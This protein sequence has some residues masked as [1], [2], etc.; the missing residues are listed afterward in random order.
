MKTSPV[1]ALLSAT[2]LCALISCSG[3]RPSS[4]LGDP[5]S[6]TNHPWFPLASGN[7]AFGKTVAVD[8][9]ITCDSCHPPAAPSFKDVSCTGCHLHALPMTN[10][11]HLGEATYDAGTSA[12]VACHPLGEKVP[13][14]HVGISPDERGGCAECHAEGAAFA[15]LP[16]ADGQPH[17]AVSGD[18]GGCH[19]RFDAWTG[20]SGAENGRFDPARDWVLTA[21]VPTFSAT[22]IVRLEPLPQSLHMPMNHDALDAGLIAQCALCHPGAAA[23]GG[24][25]YPGELHST[26]S[27]LGLPQPRACLDCH[28]ATEPVGFV[29]PLRSERSPQSGAMRHEAVAWD[30]GVAS[31][32]R[33][34]PEECAVCH[35]TPSRVS[36][37]WS[38]ALVDGGPPAFHAPLAAASLAQPTS[39]LD[40]HA[41]SR[42][43]TL[44]SSANAALPPGLVFDHGADDA[45]GD[46]GGCHASTTTWTG[47]DF[48]RAGTPAPATCLPCH[49][50]E[51]P[52]STAGWQSTTYARSPFDYGLN[53][54]GIGH[55]GDEDCAACHATTTRWSDGHFPHG[56]G[57]LAATTCAACHLSQ[58]P[59]GVVQSF[60]H[61]LNGMGDCRACHQATVVAGRYVDYVNPATGALP[62]G[63]WKGGREY[64]GD[65][66]VTSPTQ[67][68]RITQ[69]TLQRADG[70]FVTGMTSATS[71]FYNAMLH[72]S[73]ALPP[74]LDAGSA[75]TPN[76]ASCWHCHAHVNGVVTSYLEGKY[77]EALDGFRATP[78]AGVTPQ[79][80][81]ASRCL[82]CHEPM[83]PRTIVMKAASPL[84]PMD[85]SVRFTAPVTLGGQAVTNL[86]QVD[87]SVCHADPGGAWSDGVFHARIGAANPVD[88]VSCHYPLMVAPSAD[89][90]AGTTYVMRHRSSQLTLQ[91]CEA[92]HAMALGR[93]AMTPLSA[94]QWR[95]GLL[96]PNVT[97]QPTR[98]LD[99]H[100]PSEPAAS[101]QGTVVW[102][103]TGGGGTATNGGQWMSHAVPAVT[104]RDCAV[105]HQADAK[106][107]GSAWSKSTQLHANASPPGTCAS[108]HGTANGRG[109]VI[110][111]NN[112]LPLGLTNSKTTTTASTAP[113]VKDQLSHADVNVTGRDCGF[114]HSLTTP[115]DWKAARFHANFT[116]A[117]PLVT[118]GTTGR[119]STCHLNLKPGA[120]FTAFDHAPFSATSGTQDCAACHSYPGTSAAMPNW[121]GAAAMPTFISV[122]GFVIPAPPAASAGTSQ[123]GITNLPHPANAATGCAACHTSSAGGRRAFGYDH[124]STLITTKCNACHEAGSDLVG[125]AW[126]N[127][128]TEAGGA[129]D[130]RPFTLP[131]VR[132]SYKGNTLTVTY[133]RHFFPVDCGQC[134]VVPPGYGLV[135]TGTAYQTAWRFPHTESRMT[136]PSTCLMCHTRGVPN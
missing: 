106:P 12:C 62:G 45:L 123:A 52:L 78:D 31:S 58:R 121:L 13:F 57:T 118:N 3:P 66:L 5:A 117:T 70:G 65:V 104:T 11:L 28:R 44:L 23:D 21:L 50:Q 110:G 4:E 91:A 60:D 10:R 96:H 69:Y 85:H 80:Q 38:V 97:P 87:C 14:H 15:R 56:A 16:R 48:H 101:T 8:G 71:S 103:F 77:H 1:R 68:V 82:E 107:M 30:G 75:T 64:P 18:C 73:T 46:C 112:N 126:N 32:S 92:C 135:T 90:D 6:A 43:V 17:L 63:D 119:C 133:A 86:E 99:C 83:R 72:T 129:G 89:V 76:N 84:Q 34:S 19:Q 100:A 105:C 108:C 130:T 114:C 125:T 132:A 49:A 128:T 33:V 39:C 124:L 102:T 81:P 37:S 111:T 54:A 40:C 61:L 74:E 7:H 131:S 41:N 88:C 47:G 20:A 98:C 127:A 120:S 25:Y 26:L 51:R 36:S 93:A 9:P 116:A 35:A 53:D 113:G 136:N 109:T 67:F 95:T 22:R 79:P 134:H 122:G 115:L 27:N 2:A 42:P 24:S 59:A 94:A 55:G 29:G